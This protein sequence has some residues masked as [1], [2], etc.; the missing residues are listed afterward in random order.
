VTETASETTASETKA[1]RAAESVPATLRPE[2]VEGVFEVLKNR[3]L[4]D[5]KGEVESALLKMDWNDLTINS[6]YPQLVE[7]LLQVLTS[8]GFPCTKDK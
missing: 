3:G 1:A 4:P 2:L 8:Y 6:A 5:I 7:R